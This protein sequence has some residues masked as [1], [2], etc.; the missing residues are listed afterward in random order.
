MKSWMLPFPVVSGEHNEIMASAS[1]SG[2][3]SNAW[4]SP[5]MACRRI[6][7]A[8]GPGFNRFAVAFV[9]AS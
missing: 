7:V 1:C 2:V 3:G 5:G 4:S 6:R 8:I 9:V